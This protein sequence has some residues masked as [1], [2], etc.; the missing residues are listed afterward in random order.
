MYYEPYRRKRRR[1]RRRGGFGRFLAKLLISA[2][3]LA[4][5]GAALL[6][7]MPVSLLAVEP[8]GVSLSL[9][10]GLPE[11]RINVL[12]LGTDMMNRTTQRSDTM[13]IATLG[14]RSVRLTSVLRDTVVDI[15]GHGSAK[16][17]AAY[18][19][20]GPELVMRTLNENFRLNIM[21]YVTADFA[22]VIKLVDALGGVD[23]DVSDAEM[24]LVNE[25]SEEMLAQYARFNYPSRP[26]TGVHAHMDGLHALNFARIRKL[27]SDFRRTSRQRALLTVI[28]K[29][30]R[31]N[32]WNPVM[33]A[34]LVGAAADSLQ[35]NLPAPALISL[36]EKALLADDIAQMRLP[37]DG[38]FTDN[39]SSLRIDNLQ[40]NIDAFRRFA[41][42][43]G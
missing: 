25:L 10:G 42:P 7:V 40:A 23:V 24:K 30:A 1:R 16:L 9:T 19:Y 41:Y 22:S 29:K 31:E 21:Y 27:D 33:L 2:L 43:E 17:N 5:A 35:T 20:G 37:V 39:G 8:E 15:P 18:A 26:L 3:L 28:L 36:A 38:A 4:A 34:K 11:N 13:I 12:L 32:L 6:Y 14:A